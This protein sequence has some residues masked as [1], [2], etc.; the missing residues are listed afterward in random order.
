M[1]CSHEIQFK[2]FQEKVLKPQNS[3]GIGIIMFELRFKEILVSGRKSSAATSNSK[4]SFNRFSVF[5]KSGSEAYI[6]GKVGVSV[7]ESE[8]LTIVETT[9]VMMIVMIMMMMMMMSGAVLLAEHP[10]PLLLRHRLAQEGGQVQGTE[11]LH[12]LPADAE[13]RTLLE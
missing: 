10:A 7:A 5:V 9:E 8:V 1:F 13:C 3:K 12:R 6:L 2:R 11:E 4:V